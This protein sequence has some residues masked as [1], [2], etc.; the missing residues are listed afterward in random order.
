ME[1]ED[2]KPAVIRPM[3]HDVIYRNSD[4][5]DCNNTQ[6][7]W[8]AVTG[9]LGELKLTHSNKQFF[10]QKCIFRFCVNDRLQKLENM[11]H[12]NFN[13]QTTEQARINAL[14]VAL[15]EFI[16]RLNYEDDEPLKCWKLGIVSSHQN[17]LDETK[18]LIQQPEDEVFFPNGLNPVRTMKKFGAVHLLQVSKENA[19]LIMS[20]N[21]RIRW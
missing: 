11:N 19:P 8:M 4:S 9:L 15:S 10:E 14:A 16:G 18:E 20:K 6:E 1:N 5:G 2:H 21:I 3:A 7:I 17:F 13:P 12:G